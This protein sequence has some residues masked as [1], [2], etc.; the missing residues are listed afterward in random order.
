METEI[1]DK[2]FLELSQATKAKTK[3][4]LELEKAICIYQREMGDITE[5]MNDND[6]ISDFIHKWNDNV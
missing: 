4:E 5:Y 1:I 2:L 6:A 3:R